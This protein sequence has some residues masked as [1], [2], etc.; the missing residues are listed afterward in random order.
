MGMAS[1]YQSRRHSS[2]KWTMHR[3]FISGCLLGVSVGFIIYTLI[4]FIE[5]FVEPENFASLIFVVLHVFYMFNITTL[6]TKR[7]WIF[8]VMSY[9]IVDAAS[10]VFVFYD[11]LFI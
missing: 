6:E 9:L 8:W 7:Q 1:S 10:V 2:L 4:P 11:S 3:L 5:G